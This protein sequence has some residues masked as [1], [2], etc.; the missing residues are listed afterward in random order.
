VALLAWNNTYSVGVQ[1]IDDQ[2]AGL[3]ASLNELHAAMLKGQERS[4]TGRLLQDLLAYTQSHFSAEESLL[5][6]AH[7]PGLAE[8]RAKHQ[9][10]SAQ[11][12]GYAERFSRGEAALSVHLIDF[13]RD[14]LT[15]HILREDR[16]YSGW[17]SQAGLR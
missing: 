12:A 17:L 13:L 2:H 14:W 11:V 3:F 5:A 1:S 6:R 8:H 16:A 10:L 9:D 15:S 7:Y 4:I